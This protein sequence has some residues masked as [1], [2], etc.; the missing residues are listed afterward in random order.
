MET[1]LVTTKTNWLIDQ[2]H[3][4][5]GFKIRHLMISN[6]KGSFKTFDA[7]ITTTLKD[8][9]TAA[10]DLWID[11]SSINTGEEKRDEHLWSGDFFNVEIFKQILFKSSSIGQ[12]D[13]DGNHEL[14]GE[15]TMAGITK[16]VNLIVEL[17]GVVKDPWGNEKAGITVTGKINRKDWGLTWNAPLETGGILVSEEVSI[18]CEIE[19]T[20]AG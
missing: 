19:L 12:P 9:T 7:T 5:I 4:E 11:V 18:L 8:F 14:L 2:A 17:G 16:T 15:L 20:N 3:S 10:I 6:V 13:K 1:S